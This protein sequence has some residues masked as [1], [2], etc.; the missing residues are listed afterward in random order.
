MKCCVDLFIFIASLLG[1]KNKKLQGCSFYSKKRESPMS[2][3]VKPTRV[4]AGWWECR[5]WPR[6]T[7]EKLQSPSWVF[8]DQSL[9]FVKLLLGAMLLS[10]G[11]NSSL[12]FGNW[13]NVILS[14]WWAWVKGS[15]IVNGHP[16][17]CGTRVWNMHFNIRVHCHTMPGEWLGTGM[18][19]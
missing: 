19:I 1:R 15:C 6:R 10:M 17:N 9:G 11:D 14:V 2:H 3:H 16:P 7:P 12:P 13:E 4:R 8:L 5:D 18:F